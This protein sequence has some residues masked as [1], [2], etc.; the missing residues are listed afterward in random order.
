M[1]IVLIQ[2]RPV[3]PIGKTVFSQ[4]MS[5]LHEH[6][7]RKCIDKYIGDFRAIDFTCRDQFMVMSFAHFTD[8][9]SLRDMKAALTVSSSMLYH[10]GLMFISKS[11]I[12]HLNKTKDWQIYC[13][14][15]MVLA[16]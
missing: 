7:F 9:V 11:T 10:S 15:A 12:A 16:D 1:D 14:F 2:F 3:M 8:R 4:L 6:E 13:D 5:L